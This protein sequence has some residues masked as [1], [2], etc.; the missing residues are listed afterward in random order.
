MERNIE[1]LSN[2]LVKENPVLKLILGTC[3][4]LAITYTAGNGLGLGLIA[5]VV[6]VL[7]NTVVSLFHSMIPESVKVPCYI[8]IIAGF[9]SMMDLITE[10]YFPILNQ[11]LGIFLP[12]IVVNCL[13][14]GRAQDFAEKN[15]VLD[16]ALDGFSM[17]ISFTGTLTLLGIIR[18]ILGR[19]TCFGFN[20]FPA[21]LEPFTIMSTAPG[22]FF[23][24]G[25]LMA[26]VSY[27]NQKNNEK[28]TAET[29]EDVSQERSDAP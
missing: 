14:L 15:T 7:T 19:G 5:T 13:I 9:V 29:T 22:G 2:N 20:V 26:L 24:F 11:S 1:L 6:L 4:S 18:E 17:G 25:L 10:A 28:I 23:V 8:T 21:F 3:P 27:L 12:L 16:S